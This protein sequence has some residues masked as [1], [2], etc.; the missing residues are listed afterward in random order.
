MIKVNDLHKAFRGFEVLKGVTLQIPRGEITVIIGGSGQGKSVLLKH[1][2]ALLKPDKGSIEVDGEDITKLD[3][4]RLMAVRRKFGLLFQHAALFDSM[5]VFEN[6]AFPLREHRKLKEAKLREKVLELL[7]LLDLKGTEKKYPAELSGGMQKRVGLAR[8]TILDPEI[9]LYDEPTTGL[10][11]IAAE[12]VDRLIVE[13]QRRL[14]VTSVVIS[15][16]LP[17]TFRMAHHIAMLYDGKI[18]VR[19]TPEEMMTL[20]H[21]QLRRFIEL[22][23]GEQQGRVA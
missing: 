5:T 17:S 15:H 8:A 18:I 6:V 1:L 4:R 16:D 10:D 7:A 21:P 19:G 13:T 22:G 20:D 9:M 23:M 11:P 2:I 12:K 3:D 14:K